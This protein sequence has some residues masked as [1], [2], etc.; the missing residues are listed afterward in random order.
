MVVACGGPVDGHHR[1]GA[2]LA[3]ALSKHPKVQV[4]L[5]RDGLR[6]DEWLQHSMGRWRTELG[7][8]VE[9]L[10]PG[11]GP[12]KGVSRVVIGCAG[13]SEVDYLLD[14]LGVVRRE[15]HWAFASIGVNLR[16]VWLVA[17]FKD[18]RGSG[19]PVTLLCAQD[20][21][22]LAAGLR[23][24]QPGTLPMARLYRAGFPV[25]EAELNSLG[26][27]RRD[28][29][30]DC[31]PWHIRPKGMAPSS[32]RIR[33]RGWRMDRTGELTDQDLK[34]Y[35]DAVIQTLAGLEAWSGMP[36]PKSPRLFAQDRAHAWRHGEA[37]GGW[38]QVDPIKQTI[39]VLLQ[40]GF[41]ADGGAEAG[42]A[43]LESHLGPAPWEWLS[44]AA[45]LQASG[46]YWGRPI[47]EWWAVL[48]RMGELP[49]PQA[50]VT[51]KGLEGVS[52]HLIDPLRALLVQVVIDQDSRQLLRLWNEGAQAADWKPWFAAFGE[53][54]GELTIE[55]TG[56]REAPGVADWS[57]TLGAGLRGG[58]DGDGPG[59]ASGAHLER[60]GQL[61]GDRTGAVTYSM[62]GVSQ[63]HSPLVRTRPLRGARTGSDVRGESL[64]YLSIARARALDFRIGLGLEIW[65][66]PSGTALQDLVW[67]SL[68]LTGEF[69]DAYGRGTLHAALFAN[70]AGVDLLCLGE[71]MGEAVRTIARES[72]RQNKAR[73]EILA[74]RS[75]SW[76]RL[77]QR[78]RE[79]FPGSLTLAVP[80]SSLVERTDVWSGLDAVA[81]DFTS[82]RRTLEQGGG[83]APAILEKRLGM[84]LERA[85]EAS[86]GRPLV[87]W[88]L[89][90]RSAVAPGQVEDLPGIAGHSLAEDRAWEA[91]GRILRT[92]GERAPRASFVTPVSLH[93]ENIGLGSPIGDLQRAQAAF[94]D[95]DS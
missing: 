75:R 33:H 49:T 26:Q 70:L 17:T 42:R 7:L 69:F 12:R 55:P 84:E 89:G 21:S 15:S 71:G 30:V 51:G 79:A 65:A 43:F 48:A 1:G 64:L 67:P 31:R 44:R 53:R 47:H 32:H 83:G 34:S 63:P 24:L 95:G 3:W 59:L 10:G 72:E 45:G 91:L 18:P 16:E 76:K 14:H 8:E 85:I 87:L 27:A 39:Q 29:W 41:E 61:R 93:P 37:P 68:A 90:W 36:M 25:V 52:P 4:Q 5:T 94:F 62:R 6:E 20:E 57:P 66:T 46:V 28:R 78:A 77:I 11:E 56:N 92:A 50:L 38:A 82:S 22:W 81:M 19:L 13:D 23:R 40:P 73:L 80:N 35:V 88:S 58:M 9:L 2:G 54:L 86:A 60:L 74:L